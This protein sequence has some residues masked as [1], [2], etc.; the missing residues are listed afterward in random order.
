M[1][2]GSLA[3]EARLKQRMRIRRNS[4]SFFIRTPMGD[5]GHISSNRGI[6]YTVYIVT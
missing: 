2:C 1:P 3:H 6:K 4:N 5:N